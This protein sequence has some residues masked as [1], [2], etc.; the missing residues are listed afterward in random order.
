MGIF[1]NCNKMLDVPILN[2]VNMG[3]V[4]NS[5]KTRHVLILVVDSNSQQAQ[6]I[7]QL[8]QYTQKQ[9]TNKQTRKKIEIRA[10]MKTFD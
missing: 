9:Q 8:M 1:N 7:L 2:V 4:N 10:K 5:N 6:K 3:A